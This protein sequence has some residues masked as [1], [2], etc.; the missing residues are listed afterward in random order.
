MAV[1]LGAIPYLKNIPERIISKVDVQKIRELAQRNIQYLDEFS[2][3]KTLLEMYQKPLS[4]DFRQF[5]KGMSIDDRET[6]NNFSNC[7]K[8]ESLMKMIQ[9]NDGSVRS[10]FLTLNH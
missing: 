6:F 3:L 7:I 2:R 5:F 8:V 9:R 10:Y 4:R 1:I